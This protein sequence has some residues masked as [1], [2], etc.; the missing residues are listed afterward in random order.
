MKKAIIRNNSGPQLIIPKSKSSRFLQ[1][2]SS[3]RGAN[4]IDKITE[5]DDFFKIRLN[6]LLE[7]YIECRDYINQ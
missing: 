3:Q 1:W 6:C 5:D 7:D 4:R 2:I